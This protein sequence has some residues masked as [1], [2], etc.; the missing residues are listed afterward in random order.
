MDMSDE[1][2]MRMQVYEQTLEQMQQ[3]LQE[4]EEHAMQLAGTLEVLSD[5]TAVEEGTE[6]LVPVMNG[7]FMRAK[8]M[9]NDSFLV[10]VG[11]GTVVRKSLDETREMLQ[12][13]QL[14][15]IKVRERVT[16]QM[17]ELLQRVES[18]TRGQG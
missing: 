17:Q 6:M 1:E 9:K 10:G 5:I 7:V 4:L 13:Q 2:L 18:I 8:A 12:V 15:L 16:E 14:E 11:S 3:K